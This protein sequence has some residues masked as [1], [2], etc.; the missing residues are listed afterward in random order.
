LIDF[1]C[2]DNRLASLDVSNNTVL[3]ELECNKNQLTS[4]DVS[5]NTALVIFDCSKNQ[6]TDLNVTNLLDLHILDCRNNQLT[7]L[8]VSNNSRIGPIE[9]LLYPSCELDIRN[10]PTLEEVCVW[11]MPF[12]P[13]GFKL[14][15]DGSPNVYFTTDCNN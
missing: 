7:S 3:E 14:C 9:N 15:M 4:F 12:P 10:M 6:L 2:G 11:T 8:D 5:N 13:E 1:R